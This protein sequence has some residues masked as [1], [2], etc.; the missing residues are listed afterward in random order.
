MAICGI[1]LL[2]IGIVQ[3]WMFYIQRGEKC[4]VR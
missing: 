3:G 1:A 2:D 4:N